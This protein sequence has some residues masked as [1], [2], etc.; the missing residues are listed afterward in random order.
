MVGIVFRE[1]VSPRY[2]YVDPQTNTVHLIMPLAGGT[3]IGTDNTCQTVGS[4]QAFFGRGG[5]PATALNE[6][7]QYRRALQ[8]DLSLLQEENDVKRK[9]AERLQQIEQYIRALEVVQVSAVLDPLSH[10]LR[11]KY[12]EPIKPILHARSNVYSMLL[13]PSHPD[14]DY[15][16]TCSINPVFSVD[17]NGPR[18]LYHALDAVCGTLPQGATLSLQERLKAAVRAA[19]NPPIDLA[20]LQRDLSLQMYALF[21]IKS[22]DFTHE[23]RSDKEIREGK[24]AVPIDKDYLKIILGQDEDEEPSFDECVDTLYNCC[25]SDLLALTIPTSPFVVPVGDPRRQDKLL[26]LTQFFLAQVKIYCHTNNLSKMNFGAVLDGDRALSRQLAGVL[27][28]ALRNG[29]AVEQALFGFVNENRA[30]FGFRSGQSLTPQVM[31]VILETFTNQY[32]TIQNSLHFDEFL[33]LVKQD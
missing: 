6:L 4:M 7:K 30:R 19:H 12:P 5:H 27:Q 31:G 2:I 18:V 1:P 15:Y 23:N 9:K 13:C 25:V 24:A 20:A 33:V 28:Q 3:D 14:S 21:G 22:F 8:F 11:S 26:I 16:L 17:R 29:T 32:H 10:G